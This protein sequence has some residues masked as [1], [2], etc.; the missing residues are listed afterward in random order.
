[1]K[2]A[3][4]TEEV[5]VRIVKQSQA[6]I[7]EVIADFA[8]KV[9]K[10]FC[11]VETRLDRLEIG[12]IKMQAQLEAIEVRVARLEESI[13]SLTRTVDAIMKRYDDMDIENAARDSQFKKLLAWAHKVSEKTG[14]PLENL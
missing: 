13:E 10:R 12:Q 1:M 6:E 7:I 14:I 9:D 8:D 11:G 2:S 4:L 5:V 3:P